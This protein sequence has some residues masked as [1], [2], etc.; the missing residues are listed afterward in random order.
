MTRP[1][2]SH[3][4]TMAVAAAGGAARRRIPVRRTTKAALSLAAT[5]TMAA[6]LA[7][8][9]AGP[10]SAKPYPPPSIHL[11]CTAAPTNGALHGSVCALAFGQT[12]APNAYSATIAVSKA[13]S[14]GPNVTFALTAGS[15][16]PGLSMSPPSGTSAAITGNP[17]HTGTFNFTIKATDG[18]LTSTMTYQI[19]ITVQGPPDQLVC[20]PAANGGFLEN[21]VCVLPDAVIGQSY[22]G[23]MVTSHM[24]GGTLSVVSGALPPGLTLPATFTGAG[25]IVGG[26]PT[27]QVAVNFTVQGT[28]DQ[29]Q[30]LYQAYSITVDPNE[31]IAINAS[32]GTDLGGTV[33]QGFAQNF[34]LSGGAAPYT[35]SLASGQLPPGL[36]LRTF[37]DPR[38]AND[39]LAGTPTTAGTYTFTMRLAD[40]NG[41][42]A[43]QQFTITIDPPLQ[44]VSPLPAGTVGVPYSHDLI[45]QGGAPPYSW[46]VVNNISE[47]PPGLT[48][49][50]T[51]PDFNNVLTGTPTQAGTFSFPME[52][53]DSQGNMVPGT[54]TVTINP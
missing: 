48:L 13:G 53:Q 43:T 17:T 9:A 40:Y 34:F 52:V 14:A 31:P 25:D 41:Q 10:A 49:G 36:S 33:G 1:R 46:S 51:P 28:G 4:V 32:G 5:V 23:H 42:Q 24:A 26:T 19:T 22:Q 30:P 45:A 2:L 29:G 35:W 54:V 3:L 39:E 7:G 16:P 21:G 11:L 27:Q 15:L 12:T 18:G 20:T 38:D 8:L 6:A 47:L 37:S 50:T 44:I